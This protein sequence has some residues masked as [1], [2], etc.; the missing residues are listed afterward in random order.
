ML[1][2]GS[3]EIDHF[4]YIVAGQRAYTF[5]YIIGRLPVTTETDDG[6]IGFHPA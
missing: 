6:E 3:G 5:I 4:G 1:G 2:D